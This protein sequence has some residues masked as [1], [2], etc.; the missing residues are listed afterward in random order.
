[1]T[2]SRL[3]TGGG[4]CY[5]LERG[6]LPSDGVFHGCEADAVH[7]LFLTLGLE[8]NGQIERQTIGRG[9]QGQGIEPRVFGQKILEQVLENSPCDAFSVI[10][11]VCSF[12]YTTKNCICKTKITGFGQEFLFLTIYIFYRL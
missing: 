5:A 9:V 7:Q 1:M 3:H 11:L 6:D 12:D 8:A 2:N 4:C 10:F